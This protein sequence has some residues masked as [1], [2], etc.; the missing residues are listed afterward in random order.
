MRRFVSLVS[1][2]IF[3]CASLAVCRAAEDYP[4]GPDSLPQAGVPKGEVT[5][6]NWTSKIFPGSQYDYWVY[7]PKEYDASKPACVMVYLDGGGFADP[8]GGFRGPTVM[9]N[10]IFRKEM[11]V[12]IGIMINPGVAPAVG[13]NSLPRYDRSYEYD[14]PTDQYARF[15]LEEIMPE[16]G[17]KYS[18]TKDPNGRGLC[19]ASSGGICAF[20]AA[21]ARPDQFR[22][23]ISFIGSFTDLRG[24]NVFPSLIRKSEPKPLRVYLQDG[25]HD[26]DIYGGAWYLGNQEMEAALRFA[27]YETEFVVGTGGHSGQQG[28][29]ILPDAMR[30][31]WRGFPEPLRAATSNPQ[32]ILQILQAGEDW[33]PVTEG[34]QNADGL[35]SDS[36]GNVYVSDTRNNR[37]VKI[38]TDGKNSV[39]KDGTN[40]ATALA[41]GP[42]SKLYA[43]QPVHKRIVAYD[44]NGKESAVASGLASNSLVVNHQGQIYA[45]DSANKKI[46]LITSGGHK[47]SVDEGIVDETGI[48]FTPDQSLL[49][50]S[51]NAPGKFLY[52]FRTL[53]DG[54]LQDRQPYFDVVIPY[55]EGDSGSAGL[56]T[57]A[58]GWLYVASKQGIQ[59]EDQAGR[60]NSIINNPERAA[61]TAVVFGGTNLDMLYATCNNKVYRRKT[62]AKG[63]LAFADPIKPN[64][65][66]L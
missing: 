7:V 12:T 11:P 29:A 41:F 16:V 18:L 9:D 33:Q 43:S 31:V 10:L 21:W 25:S 39:F 57:D 47:S 6:Y 49:L 64:G 60:V 37:I 19:G 20:A 15:L 56:A 1:A 30:W 58:N 52:S 48:T 17:K 13:K 54:K 59:V 4:I 50:V 27:G 35:A 38:T 5:H 62:K 26:Q 22:R 3:L 40:G 32:P 65:P 44:V 61:T 36:A 63:V 42:D 51:H 23:V 2:L 24:G 53:P 34:I 46:W 28:A 45:N 8:N 14:A 66:H 55:G